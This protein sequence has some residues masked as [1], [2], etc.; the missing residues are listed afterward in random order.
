MKARAVGRI[1]MVAGAQRPATM[2]A[3]PFAQKARGSGGGGE[4]RAHRARR[5]GGVAPNPRRAE[6]GGGGV[7]G[8]GV[9]FAAKIPRR[10]IVASAR[11]ASALRRSGKREKSPKLR[12]K[13]SRAIMTPGNTKKPSHTLRQG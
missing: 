1:K 5:A 3:A 12:G 7:A 10:V 9:T 4:V 13:F 6:G 2:A 8:E 11:V